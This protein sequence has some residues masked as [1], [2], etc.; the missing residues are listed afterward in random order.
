MSQA[1][2]KEP[3][4]EALEYWE[5]LKEKKLKLQR[6]ESCGKYVYYPREFCP[7]DQGKLVYEEVS[8][9]GKILS[10]TVVEKATHPYFISKTPY[11]LAMIQLEEGPT[12]LSQIVDAMPEEVTFDMQVEVTFEHH[13]YEDVN[14]P[15]FRPVQNSL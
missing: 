1:Y 7:H 13:I 2:V 4:E 8:G 10:Y 14:L 12:M 5:G 11:V 15:V 3:R 9:K 6:C